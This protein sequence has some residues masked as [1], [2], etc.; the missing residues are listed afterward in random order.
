MNFTD[1]AALRTDAKSH[2][3]QST[4]CTALG[5]L[6]VFLT[7]STAED[8]CD[9]LRLSIS[10]VAP[11]EASFSAKCLPMPVDAPVTAKVLPLRSFGSSLAQTSSANLFGGA[12]RDGTREHEVQTTPMKPKHPNSATAFLRYLLD[13]IAITSAYNTPS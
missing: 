13:M 4:K 3:S 12:G 6:A 9:D 5:S 1:S 2:K 8:E 10:T 7:S 11:R